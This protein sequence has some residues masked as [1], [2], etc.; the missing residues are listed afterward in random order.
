MFFLSTEKPTRPTRSGVLIVISEL[1][2]A[3]LK[4]FNGNATT[5]G[6]SPEPTHSGELIV[7]ARN[8]SRR[9]WG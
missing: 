3:P 1:L 9:D 4:S 8:P 2:V 6:R 7:T 5:T